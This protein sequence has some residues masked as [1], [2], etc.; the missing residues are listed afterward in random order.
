[1][2]VLLL[3]VLQ[4]VTLATLPAT[5]LY[6]LLGLALSPIL[7]P[8]LAFQRFVAF[9]LKLPLVLAT[10][11]VAI[12]VG[13]LIAGTVL[14]IQVLKAM[15]V[16]FTPLLWPL[17]FLCKWCKATMIV[18]HVMITDTLLPFLVPLRFSFLAAIIPKTLMS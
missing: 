15:W 2:S 8:Y 16:T 3:P 13:G 12:P 1:M 5:A 14:T 9:L 4:L 7:L 10:L 11:P 6:A 18:S 17:Y